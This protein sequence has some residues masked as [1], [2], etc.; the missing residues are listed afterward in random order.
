[1]RKLSKLKGQGGMSLVEATI[2]LLVLMLLTGVIAPSITE[3]VSDAKRVKVKEDC[4]ALGILT[5]YW[6]ASLPGGCFKFNSLAAPGPGCNLA[7]R[8]PI[9]FSDGPDILAGDVVKTAGF[10]PDYTPVDGAAVI[11]WDLEDSRGDPFQD[12]FTTNAPSYNIFASPRNVKPWPPIPPQTQSPVMA[13]PWGKR[14]VVNTMFLATA[15]DSTAAVPTE[16]ST[17]GTWLRKVFCL[18]AGSNGL[19]QTPFAG[20]VAA[21]VTPVATRPCAVDRGG[22]DYFYPIGCMP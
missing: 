6:W 8:V 20:T 9:L 16:G 2:I 21:L 15:S 10:A 11:N 5:A 1:M 17:G 12:Q 7:N 22:D 18:S 3:F 13:D 19:Y 4:E 14:Y